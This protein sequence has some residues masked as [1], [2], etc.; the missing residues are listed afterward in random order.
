MYQLYQLIH[1]KNCTVQVKKLIELRILKEIE[2][3]GIL[4]VIT[5]SIGIEIEIDNKVLD[6]SKHCGV[7]RGVPERRERETR[8]E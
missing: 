7:G 3:S 8:E 2:V 1:L 5:I 4:I 6:V